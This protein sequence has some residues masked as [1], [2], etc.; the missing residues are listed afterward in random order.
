MTQLGFD[1]RPPQGLPFLNSLWL[2]SVHPFLLHLFHWTEGGCR[3]QSVG[4]FVERQSVD[5]FISPVGITALFPPHPSLLLQC[6]LFLFSCLFPS[7]LQPKT[8]LI[9]C[10]SQLKHCNAFGSFT[11]DN[12]SLLT[13]CD[14]LCKVRQLKMKQNMPEMC[15][16][17]KW[18][19]SMVYSQCA[20][21]EISPLIFQHPL[22]VAHR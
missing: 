4:S 10:F 1:G 13:S 2:N 20:W 21:K 8:L 9:M 5:G 14:G 19:L 15:I 18:H 22:S 6:I 11:A 16:A 3:L 12:F 7:V 17:L